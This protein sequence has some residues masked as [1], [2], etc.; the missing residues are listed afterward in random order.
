MNEDRLNELLERCDSP[1]E[2]E[3]LLNLYLHLTTGASTPESCH[4][5]TSSR[6]TGTSSK[7]DAAAKTG[8]SKTTEATITAET[9]RW[10]AE[11]AAT[12]LSSGTKRK[13]LAR[14]NAGMAK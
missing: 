8:S 13:E 3:L 6:T 11:S 12:K 10:R 4:T 14:V 7:A 5:R 2:R 1:I 9:R